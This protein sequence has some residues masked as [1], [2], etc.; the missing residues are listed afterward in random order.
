MAPLRKPLSPVSIVLPILFR[1]YPVLFGV[2]N[3]RGPFKVAVVKGA[4]TVGCSIAI[5]SLVRGR[6]GGGG[7]TYRYI[8]ILF[9]GKLLADYLLFTIHKSEFE[10]KKFL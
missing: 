7:A 1:N 4:E 6:A 5:T 3:T 2:Y 9:C 8:C 10:N